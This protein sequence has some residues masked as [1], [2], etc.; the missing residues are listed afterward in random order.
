MQH[1]H[2][3]NVPAQMQVTPPG[4]LCKCPGCRRHIDRLEALNAQL[5]RE[6]CRLRC[7]SEEGARAA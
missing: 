3:S 1:P 5:A 4:S 2:A 6:N 7:E